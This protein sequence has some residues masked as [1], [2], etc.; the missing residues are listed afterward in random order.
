LR[1]GV[2]ESKFFALCGKSNRRNNTVDCLVV[3]DSISSDSVEVS[4]FCSFTR[5]YLEQFIWRPKLD[6]L[7]FNSTDAEEATRLERAF[8]ESEIFEMVK[9]L[10]GDKALGL[11]GFSLAFFQSSWMIV[12]EDVMNFFHDIHQGCFIW[13]ISLCKD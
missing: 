6:A 3:N 10:N 7:T 9:T 13:Q 11:D 2:Q 12:K 1:E 8:E 5:L 4:I